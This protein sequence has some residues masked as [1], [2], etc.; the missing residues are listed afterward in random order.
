MKK[1]ITLFVLISIKMFS[2]NYAVSEIPEELKKDANY[3]VRN[4][5]SEYIIKAENNIELK[6]KIIISIL[7]KAGEGGSYVYI[8]YDKYSKISDVKI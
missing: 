2:Q 8:P 7:S 5:S 3:V 6:K 1:L 4:N